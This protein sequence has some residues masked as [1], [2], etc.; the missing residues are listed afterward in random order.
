MEGSSKIEGSSG[1]RTI[2]ENSDVAETDCDKAALGKTN[3]AGDPSWTLDVDFFGKVLG[4]K[5]ICRHPDEGQIL[6]TTTE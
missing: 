4:I 5:D 6:T 1:R 3:V 2:S